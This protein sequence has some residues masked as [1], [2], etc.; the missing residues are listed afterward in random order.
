VADAMCR[1]ARLKCIYCY[2]RCVLFIS[3]P[4]A[5]LGS[6]KKARKLYQQADFLVLGEI[7]RGIAL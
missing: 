2:F 5:W 6:I 3:S 4:D 1:H 7:S